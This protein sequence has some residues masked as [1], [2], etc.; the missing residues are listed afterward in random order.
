MLHSLFTV[1]V[2]SGVF[3]VIFPAAVAAVSNVVVVVFAIGVVVV[4]GD[5]EIRL[6]KHSF[7]KI[8]F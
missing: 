8:G 7:Q 4:D 3:V 6:T 5:H 1:V 2:G